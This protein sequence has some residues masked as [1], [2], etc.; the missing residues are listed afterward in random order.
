MGWGRLTDR[1]SPLA[2]D[3][4]DMS[5]PVLVP[6]GRAVTGRL[7]APDADSVV[8]ACPPHPQHGGSRSDPRLR[9]VSD[10]VVPAVACL[11]FDYGEW[12]EGVGERIDAENALAWARERYDRV[13]VFGY[14][15]GA[16]VALQAAAQATPDACSV[17]APPAD[18]VDSLDECDCPVQVVVGK[19]DTTVDWEPVVRRARDLGHTVETLP[20]DHSFAG[21]FDRLGSAVGTFLSDRL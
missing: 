1:Y 3:G 7:D 15:F 14:S 17:L 4:A 18:A 10:A 13:G 8:V 19:R 12:D 5:K 9:A 11:R 16:G 6:G 20:A 21:Q 2:A